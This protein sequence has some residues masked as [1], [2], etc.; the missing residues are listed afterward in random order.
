MCLWNGS[1]QNITLDGSEVGVTYT[2][3]KDGAATTNQQLASTQG[4]TIIFSV[5]APGVFTVQASNSAG[6]ATM[7]GSAF[8]ASNITD[9][10]TTSGCLSS[11][12]VTFSTNGALAFAKGAGLK[13]EGTGMALTQDPADL[14]AVMS[15]EGVYTISLYAPNGSVCKSWNYTVSGTKTVQAVA[16]E[17]GQ[18][19]L[20]NPTAG[21]SYSVTPGT[22]SQVS[23]S[24]AEIVYKATASGTY[25]I[26]DP[27]CGV[28][29][30]ISVTIPD[31]KETLDKNGQTE[32]AA[33]GNKIYLD[34]LQM[35]V[36]YQ[37][38]RDGV[39]VGTNGP[40]TST[41][42]PFAW[43]ADQAGTYTFRA[44]AGGCS[45]DLSLVY[46]VNAMP[47]T[48]Y[49][50]SSVCDGAS[51]SISLSSSEKDVNYYLYKEGSATPVDTRV[52]TGTQL[53]FFGISDAGVYNV[54][55]KCDISDAGMQMT[56]TVTIPAKYEILK[57]T[58][59]AG[60]NITVTLTGSQTGIT[61]QLYRDATAVGTAQAG[62]GGALTFAVNSAQAGAYTVK[63][64]GTNI[65][66]VTMAGVYTVGTSPAVVDVTAPACNTLQLSTTEVG[67][68]YTI[69]KDGAKTT[70]TI[71]GNGSSQTITLSGSG[72]YTVKA[73]C[74]TGTEYEMNGSV[75]VDDDLDGTIKITSNGISGCAGDDN[76]HITTDRAQ[77]GVTYYLYK[78]KDGG[79]ANNTG[80]YVEATAADATTLSFTTTN[81]DPVTFFVSGA[82]V[83]KVKAVSKSSCADSKFLTGTFEVLDLGS[84]TIGNVGVCADAVQANKHAKLHVQ[85]A[86]Y[87]V[88][89]T[90]MDNV[91]KTEVAG[92]SSVTATNNSGDVYFDLNPGLSAGVYYVKATRNSCSVTADISGLYTVTDGQTR[93][94]VLDGGIDSDKLCKGGFYSFGLDGVT[95]GVTYTLMRTFGG[96]EY[97]ME[98][99][100][101]DATTTAPKYFSPMSEP[102]TYWVKA[103]IACETIS[104][105]FYVNDSKAPDVTLVETGTV[106]T[107]SGV[108]K[109][110]LKNYSADCTY[111]LYK[112]GVAQAATYSAGFTVTQSGVY[113]VEAVSKQGCGTSANVPGN[114]VTVVMAPQTNGMQIKTT[115]TQCETQV[116]L[117]GAQQGVE[118]Y[119]YVKDPVTGDAKQVGARALANA[120]GVVTFEGSLSA[121]TDEDITYYVMAEP[122]SA[123]GDCKVDVPGSFT[124]HKKPVALP[125]NPQSYTYCGTAGSTIVLTGVN[126]NHTYTLYD[127]ATDLPVQTRSVVSASGTIEFKNDAVGTSV[128]IPEGVYYV[129]SKNQDGCESEKGQLITI[130]KIDYNPAVT[131]N[132]QEVQ[133]QKQELCMAVDGAKHYDVN[134]FFKLPSETGYNFTVRV[135]SNGVDKSITVA[136]GLASGIITESQPNQEYIFDFV[137]KDYNLVAGDV[138]ITVDVQDNMDGCAAQ[139]FTFSVLPTP[140]K[141]NI[142]SW[143]SE[144]TNTYVCEGDEVKLTASS[145]SPDNSPVTY[146]W[147]TDSKLNQSVSSEAIYTFAATAQGGVP[148]VVDGV[149]YYVQTY[150]AVAYNTNCQ[151]EAT[152]QEVLVK[153]DPTA[154][155]IDPTDRRWSLCED[156]DPVSLDEYYSGTSKYFLVGDNQN[157]ECEITM[158]KNGTPVLDPQVFTPTGIDWAKAAALGALSCADAQGKPVAN[159][160]VT[161]GTNGTT[162]YTIRGRSAECEE[163]FYVDGEF[164]VN[165][166]KSIGEYGIYADACY[167]TNEPITIQGYPSVISEQEINNGYSGVLYA[168]GVLL[169]DYPENDGWDWQYTFS[170]VSIQMNR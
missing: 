10:T 48:A 3:Y 31:G 139:S 96:I 132:L 149:T 29:G 133:G 19:R 152:A 41:T 80:D 43:T 97:T 14:E 28:V 162:T 42:T 16:G 143:N 36:T 111:T 159:I 103:D 12:K 81:T 46:T 35:G 142:T 5:S 17:C 33:S 61:Y 92:I 109:I 154:L 138:T 147:F 22:A 148:R 66:D 108:Y 25:T 88:T 51:N 107:T 136:D 169:D 166:K 62:N 60:N 101:A 119:L 21:V 113:T 123:I 4:Q 71:S 127:N 91:T 130:T 131:S 145:S 55:A 104:G 9:L 72:V 157:E 161:P 89:Y 58:S 144:Q 90:L 98:T 118:Y 18:F 69:Y 54:V 24:T 122:A 11:K 65:C 38:L 158:V 47:T 102:G 160:A 146:K 99:L 155:K 93:K 116:I 85:N 79:D 53:N 52:G 39:T 44:E 37:M 49:T 168:D 77:A 137:P 135:A 78:L 27:N 100:Y 153:K 134:I 83:Y 120:A 112:D 75:T 40:V 125:K 128:G 64:S 73:K 76:T 140:T 13:V 115:T 30:T 126:V 7:S 82:G 87:G 1:A 6:T 106:C 2:L 70:Q 156:S 151:S 170:P 59:C 23:S 141:P 50:V 94:M 57:G 163:F 45:Q 63:A 110:V 15:T 129:K 32:C 56:G 68:T 86:E 34:N 105:S 95:G 117:T 84:A 164:T 67:V 124:I 167:C 20:L 114:S 8:I 26:S 150:Y 121:P 165:S 74:G